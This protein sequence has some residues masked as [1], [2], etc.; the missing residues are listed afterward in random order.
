[1]TSKTSASTGERITSIVQKLDAIGPTKLVALFA[2]SVFGIAAIANEL[3]AEINPLSS[4]RAEHVMLATNDYNETL[5]W[6]QEQLGFRIK[7]EWTVS[8]FPDL[9][10]AY[11][12]KNGFIIEVVASPQTSD[13]ETPDDFAERLQ[14]PGIGHFAFFV[15]DVDAAIASL[16]AQGIQPVLPP[17]SFPNSGRRVAFFEDNN[18]HLIEFLEEL[19]PSDRQPYTGEEL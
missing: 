7:H 18:G 2:S 10:L 8:E 9:E 4:M 5:D 1:M 19:P 15:D 13:L 12:E 6:Y 11:L 17:T 3:R 16:E 14:Q